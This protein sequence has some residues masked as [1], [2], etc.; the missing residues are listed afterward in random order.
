MGWG[1]NDP[2]GVDFGPSVV[3]ALPVAAGTNK[4]GHYFW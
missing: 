1:K 3:H 4:G 2:Q